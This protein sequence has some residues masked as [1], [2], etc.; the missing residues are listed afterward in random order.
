M[1]VS[2]R[3]QVEADAVVRAEPTAT[4]A[5][6]REARAREG[7]LIVVGARPRRWFE[8]LFARSVASQVVERAKRSVLVADRAREDV[9][10]AAARLAAIG[11]DACLDE[12]RLHDGQRAPRCGR[13]A[14][15]PP[16]LP[17]EPWPPCDPWRQCCA[18]TMSG[19]PPPA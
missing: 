18:F 19:P 4:D 10:A 11:T 9:D 15:Q 8:R 2:A 14:H 6:L 17:C 5:I 3:L 16:W 7:D 12:R 1:R 13:I